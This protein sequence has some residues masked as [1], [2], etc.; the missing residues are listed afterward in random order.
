MTVRI[1]LRVSTAE[2][3]E[4]TSLGE[5]ERR[6]RGA[7]MAI[8]AE[9]PVI[10]RDIGVSGATPLKSRPAGG[11]LWRELEPG[12]TVIAAKMDRL[13]RSA[14][15]ALEA[16]ESMAKRGVNLVLMDMGADP[17]NGD[18]VGRLYFTIMAA[19]A[20]FERARI[21]ERMAEGRKAKQAKGGFLG[22][23][24]AKYGYV[25]IGSGKSATLAEVPA[26]MAVLE[27]VR[28]LRS[29]GRTLTGIAEHLESVGVRSRTGKPF[30]SEQIRRMVKEVS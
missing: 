8:S 5:Q 9:E 13:F 24:S 29:E 3:A 11:R 19:M 20:E 26:E 30:L 15:D 21:A 25:R 22:G 27:T 18:G 1:I 14:R 4:G 6:C 7:A 12:D 28:S 16:S 23:K 10:Y 2:Q 17:V